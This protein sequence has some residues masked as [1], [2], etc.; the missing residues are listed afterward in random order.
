MLT[1]RPAQ[2]PFAQR[3]IQN[4]LF[5]FCVL[6][7]V[8]V[9]VF[10][11]TRQ[12]R[13]RQLAERMREIE[14]TQI[15]DRRLPDGSSKNEFASTS[16]PPQQPAS[17]P[18]P[19]AG[20]DSAAADHP[21]AT[22][23]TASLATAPVSA[24][25]AMP[26]P[27]A[28]SADEGK[29]ASAA[30]GAHAVPT[31][32]RVIFAQVGRSILSDLARYADPRTVST[33]GSIVSGVL[34]NI[35]SRLKVAQGTEGWDQLDSSTRPLKLNQVVE[36][37]GG[38]RDETVGQFLGFVI[39]LTPTLIDENEVR[40]QLRSW[41]Y[42]RDAT[43]TQ[44]EEFSIPTPE[45]F[46]IPRQGGAFIAGALPHRTLGE[47]ERRFYEP[48]KVLRLLSSDEFR[49]GQFDFVIYLEPR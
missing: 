2:K 30:A 1:Y 14:S 34:P 13:H 4:T 16:P 12:Q 33:Q 9:S 23:A 46:S 28:A 3:L 39:E 35:Q 10:S 7:L 27:A 17:A 26:T 40:F 25:S 48:L 22:G 44:V 6:T 38:Q 49:N 19:Q 36:Y 41:R 29:S 5:Q 43:P 20:A 15:V 18:A 32:L 8:V 37:Y 47:P 31:S 45:S 42:L 24:G 11:I 21:E